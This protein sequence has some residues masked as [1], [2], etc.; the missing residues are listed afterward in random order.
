MSRNSPMGRRLEK[1]SHEWTSLTSKSMG[2]FPHREEIPVQVAW[3][4][5]GQAQ[6][7]HGD[8]PKIRAIGV[9]GVITFLGLYYWET[10]AL[11]ALP[12]PAEE[13]LQQPAP[14]SQIVP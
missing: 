10:S 2:I 14:V 3:L 8:C 7:A 13:P 6:G 1:L 5:L 11:A 9:T 4:S 12:L